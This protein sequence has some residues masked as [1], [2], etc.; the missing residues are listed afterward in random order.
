MAGA[1][2]SDV[3]SLLQN[4]LPFLQEHEAENNLL[5]GILDRLQAGVFTLTAPPL[6]AL[7]QEGQSIVGVAIR[8][9]PRN[10]V[11]SVMSQGTAAFLARTLYADGVPA[12]GVVGPNMAARA[13]ADAWCAA[14]GQQPAVALRE[15]VYELE[16][17]SPPSEVS[18]RFR[19]AEPADRETL[20]AWIIAFEREALGIAEPDRLEREA[21]AERVIQRTAQGGMGIWEDRG[22]PVCFAGYNG[23]TPH[24]A[25]IGPVYT[26]PERRGHGYASACTAA[27][28]QY[29]LDQGAERCFLHTDLA[30]PTSNKIYQAIGYRWVGEALEMRFEEL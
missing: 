19:W 16:Q 24:G 28:S 26:P 4:V 22:Q 7:A 18:G 23:R 12:P 30:N 8:T 17:V 2:F 1:Y 3:P 21:W 29:L 14:S 10:V 6:L 5:F 25:R 15:G 20:I 27:V 13:F 9:P 11:V